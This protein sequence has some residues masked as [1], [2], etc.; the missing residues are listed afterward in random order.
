MQKTWMK[1]AAPVAAIAMIAGFAAAPVFAATNAGNMELS[2]QVNIDNSSQTISGVSG[3][4]TST[5]TTLYG[6][7]GYFLNKNFQFGIA[8]LLSDT[9][10][11]VGGGPTIELAISSTDGFVKWHFILPDNPVLVPWVGGYL[12]ILALTVNSAGSTST[13]SGTSYGPAVGIKYFVQ[14]N[15][16]INA[17][18]RI[19]FSSLT[20][21]P[22]SGPSVS[23]T[24]SDNILLFG[25]SV[26][27][28][29]K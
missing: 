16:S 8:E 11:S 12:G 17:E 20:I 5:T 15:T 28:G 21:T 13:G 6:S 25:L 23:A 10:A 26:Y 1:I 22:P 18:Y 29:G 9:K 4:N 3:S 27:F 14:E 2:A 19:L 24:Q 7:F